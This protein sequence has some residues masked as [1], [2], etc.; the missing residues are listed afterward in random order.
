MIDL[1]RK[2]ETKTQDGFDGIPVGAVCGLMLAIF[3]AITAGIQM[4]GFP[5]W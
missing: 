4:I 5:I 2:K 3:V 1:N